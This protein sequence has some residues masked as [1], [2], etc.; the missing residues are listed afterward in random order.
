MA[1][2]EGALE[3]RAGGAN[4]EK[5]GK[6]GLSKGHCRCKGPQHRRGIRGGGGRKAKVL[7]VGHKG[8]RPELREA[9]GLEEGQMGPPGSFL[10]QSPAVEV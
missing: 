4:V 5:A 7:T 6:P 8:K 2:L 3:V 10:V 1:S 9:G